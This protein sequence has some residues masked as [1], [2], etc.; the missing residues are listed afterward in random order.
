MS[1]KILIVDDKKEYL[2]TAMQYII[3]DS[4]PYA[5]LSAPNGEIGI[6]IA[7]KELPDVIVMDWEMPG[8]SGVEATRQLKN[9]KETKDIPIIIATGIR[10]TPDDLRFALEAGASDFLRKPLDKTEFLARVNSHLKQAE[11]VKTIK[12]QAD[13]I[14]A[15]ENAKLNDMVQ[16]LND[17]NQD[18]SDV[19]TF[20]YHTLT[21]LAQK[22]EEIKVGDCFDDDVE[23][24][25][26]ALRTINQRAKSL[27]DRNLF[28]NKQFVEC[29]LKSHDKL[30][31]REIQLCYLIKQG[32]QTKEIADL[33]FREPGSV[34]VSRSRLRKKLLLDEKENLYTY[35]NNVSSI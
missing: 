27:L 1:K 6:E 2:Q 7:T 8:I 19:L 26:S 14:L 35:L 3:E 10:I 11:Y 17:A 16:Y 30:T 34:K 15:A 31:A 20:Y 18:T 12:S 32:L 23:S 24:V 13:I 21:L 22:L 4:I 29:L 28:P 33:T 5:L 9:K 25:I